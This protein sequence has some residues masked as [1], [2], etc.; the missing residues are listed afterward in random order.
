MWKSEHF[1]ELWLR[2]VNQVK[3]LQTKKLISKTGESGFHLSATV[4]NCDATEISSQEQTRRVFQNP[5]TSLSSSSMW[6][7]C[8]QKKLSL[9]WA[10]LIYLVVLH[11]KS[12]WEEIK[13]GHYLPFVWNICFW[14]FQ[15]SIKLCRDIWIRNKICKTLQM[16]ELNTLISRHE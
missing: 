14:S 13:S 16:R 8:I 12:S 11:M 4:T 2:M 3:S 9:V 15:K 10:E 5:F 7:S 1:V 6:S